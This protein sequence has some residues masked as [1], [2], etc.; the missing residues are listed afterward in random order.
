MAVAKEVKFDMLR[1]LQAADYVTLSNA[2]CGAR[3]RNETSEMGKQ[4]DSFSDLISFV[5]APAFML[6][7]L[8]FRS[9]VDQAI[10]IFFVFCGVSRLARF[11]V[12]SNLTP[13][14]VHGNSLYHEG[15]PT[16]YEALI[17]S[18]SVAVAQWLSLTEGLA[19]RVSFPGTWGEVHVAIVP[20]IVFGAGMVSKSFKLKLDGGLSIPASTVVIFSACWFASPP[21]L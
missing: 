15:F 21:D 20:I 19:S 4:L 5:L 11:N 2:L 7:S 10:L 14:D 8:G 18:T 17:V 3:W 9:P 12:S 13:K 1:R 16:A 6:Y